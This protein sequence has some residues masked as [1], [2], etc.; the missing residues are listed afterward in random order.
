MA[1]PPDLVTTVEVQGALTTLTAANTAEL[2]V[3]ITQVSRAIE[4][5]CDRIL[6][7]P[8]TC[9]EVL[10]P[11][12]SR[13]L[14]VR[15]KPITDIT[16]VA[17]SPWGVM[18]VT[19]TDTTNSRATVALT[20]TGDP[21]YTMAALTGLRLYSLNAGNATTTNLLFVTYPTLDQLAAQINTI[22]GWSAAVASGLGTKSCAYLSVNEMGARGCLGVQVPLW[23]FTQEITDYN[24]EPTRGILT[25]GGGWPYTGLP[26]VGWTA[27]TFRFPDR[28]WGA[29]KRFG[30]VRVVY[31]AGYSA[32][33]EDLKRACIACIQATFDSESFSGVIKSQKTS[34]ASVEIDPQMDDLV[35]KVAG[36]MLRSYRRMAC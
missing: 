33:P 10:E 4:R 16:L 13:T 19:N 35:R 34:M 26:M 15:E 24:P 18:N 14:R 32:I 12:R 17:A 31:T 11:G 20:M 9:D 36:G 7:G 2:S 29:N 8:V 22:A 6:A 27:D 23:M 25:I 3:V 5:F 28:T 30:Q 21:P 1:T